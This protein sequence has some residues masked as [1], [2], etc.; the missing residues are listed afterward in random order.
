MLAAAVALFFHGR[1][2]GFGIDGEAAPARLVLGQVEREAVG[3]VQGEGGLARQHAALAKALRRVLKQAHAA[4]E[5]G[6]EADLL[7]LQR[8]LDEGLGAAQLGIGLAHLL[9]QRRHQPVHQRI[10]GAQQVS[11][12]HGPAH[13]P[14]QDI[15]AALI[16]GG[17]AVGDQ[18]G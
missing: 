14:A 16:G 13:D 3:V 7:L 8:V 17:H 1:V 5:G 4:A 6:A 10:G 15:S 2:E 9:H 12:A 18:E 11:V